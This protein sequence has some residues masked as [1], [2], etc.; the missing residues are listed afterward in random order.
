M[1]TYCLDSSSKAICRYACARPSFEKCFLP[2]SCEN[3]S[4]IFG[5]GY[6]SSLATL[7]TVSL[8][9]PHILTLPLGL[10]TGTIGAVQ[11]ENCTGSMTPL[12]YKCFSSCSTLLPRE[13]GIERKL[14]KQG[15]TFV[16][17]ESL[18]VVPLISPNSSLNN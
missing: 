1:T 7:L 8:K 16:S 18:A 2:A 3:K 10:T 15:W 17:I 12:L 14:Q 4:S 13:K 9:S 11:S 5:S 6:V